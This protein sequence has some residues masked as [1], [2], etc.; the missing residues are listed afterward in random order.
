MVGDTKMCL[1]DEV[2]NVLTCAFAVF[3]LMLKRQRQH[4]NLRTC[5]VMKNQRFRLF[6]CSLLYGFSRKYLVS[7]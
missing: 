2:R 1:Q 6:T 4:A 3:V 5:A 7:W